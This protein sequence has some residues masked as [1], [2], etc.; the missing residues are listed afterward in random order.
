MIYCSLWVYSHQI[1]PA[2]P[3]MLL[4]GDVPDKV[5]LS[6]HVALICWVFGEQALTHAI[7]AKNEANFAGIAAQK[8]GHLSVVRPRSGVS[9]VLT[10][11]SPLAGV[12]SSRLAVV[13]SR[14]LACLEGCG[15][16][17]CACCG[18]QR[19]VYVIMS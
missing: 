12:G 10:F 6:V 15:D 17:N 2:A 14:G 11:S 18:T 1:A 8:G 16:P 4:P 9:H 3:E 13:I 5:Y 19:I 7:N